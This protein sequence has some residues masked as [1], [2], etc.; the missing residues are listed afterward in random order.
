MDNWLYFTFGI[1]AA[2]SF[3]F[4][5]ISATAFWLAIKDFKEIESEK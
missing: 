4:I 2:I 5:A 1:T 3:L